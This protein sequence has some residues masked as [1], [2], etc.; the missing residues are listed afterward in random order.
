MN[1]ETTQLLINR[2][3]KI[4]SIHNVVTEMRLEQQNQTNNIEKN[5][6]NIT[7]ALE[8]IAVNQTATTE[9]KEAIVNLVGEKKPSIIEK[10]GLKD[11]K[12]L[13]AYSVLLPVLGTLVYNFMAPIKTLFAAIGAK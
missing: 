8:A 3:D 9:N 5:S 1:D 11:P 2:L 7:K 13:V 12:V 4:D 10:M 6:D